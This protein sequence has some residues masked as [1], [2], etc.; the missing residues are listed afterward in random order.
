MKSM[1]RVS[2]AGWFKGSTS[3]LAIG[4]DIIS[5]VG[6]VIFEFELLIHAVTFYGLASPLFGFTA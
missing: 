1:P 4:C 2:G 3:K 6:I 5:A